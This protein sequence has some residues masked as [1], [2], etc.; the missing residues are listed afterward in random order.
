MGLQ[1]LTERFNAHVAESDQY[2]HG[3]IIVDKRIAQLDFRV[4]SSHMSYLFGHQTGR[5]L[6]NIVEAPLFADSRLTTGLQI[7][8]NVSSLIYTNH[9]H[10]YCRDIEG[11][12]DY[13]H[14]KQFWPRL[15]ALQF[16]SKVLVGHNT[17]GFRV[18]DQT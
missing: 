3:V 12:E 1:Y 14:T 10:Y 8:D 9:Y 5:E 15:D 11:A 13:S 7:A 6:T 17:Y 16:K 18:I 4:A 2:N